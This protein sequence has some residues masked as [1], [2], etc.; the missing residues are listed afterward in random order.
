M[1]AREMRGLFNSDPHKKQY[2]TV[3]FVYFSYIRTVCRIQAIYGRIQQ[4]GS[5]RSSF[6]DLSRL[7]VSTNQFFHTAFIKFPVKNEQRMTF[8]TSL[9]GLF[10]RKKAANQFSL[11]QVQGVLKFVKSRPWCVDCNK[12]CI[13]NEMKLCENKAYR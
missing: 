7:A 12:S 3:N 6:C 11:G 1:Y 2:L 5:L 4:R 9:C 13:A 10:A 8:I